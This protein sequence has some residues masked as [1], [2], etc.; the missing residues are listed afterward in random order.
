M[1]LDITV[2]GCAEQHHPAE[3][4]II[5]MA[6]AVEGPAKQEVFSRALAIEEPLSAELGDLED[7]DAVRSWSVSQV[8]VFS[9]RPWDG[10]A[11]HGRGSTLHVAQVE[12]LAEFTDF[13][14]LSSFVDHWSG[15]EGVEINGIRWDVSAKNRSIHETEVRRSAVDDAIAKAQIY[16]SAVRRGKVVAVQIADP[17]MLDGVHD[18]PP[19]PYLVHSAEETGRGL[20]IT[21]EEIV[22]RVEVDA[23]FVAD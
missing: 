18:A 20:T 1:T 22:I 21:P 16:A 12:V 10:D 14:L 13:E 2:R 9:R 6:V 23:K 11:D 17:G 4:A 5:S 8:R 3:R 7:R 15:A 19:A